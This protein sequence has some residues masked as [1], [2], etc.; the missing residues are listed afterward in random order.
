MWDRAGAHKTPRFGKLN[1]I[2]HRVHKIKS[3]DIL[4]LS[5]WRWAGRMETD[6][7]M[8][9]YVV[10][11]FRILNSLS[12]QG[13]AY[14][15]INTV[16]FISNLIFSR[17]WNRSVACERERESIVPSLS[18]VGA[19]RNWV[20]SQMAPWRHTTWNKSIAF[21]KPKSKFKSRFAHRQMRK[22]KNTIF[23]NDSSIL[24]SRS[25]CSDALSL[26]TFA[27]APPSGECCSFVWAAENRRKEEPERAR[28]C[29]RGRKWFFNE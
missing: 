16:D 10:M 26:A 20:H 18:C 17:D 24:Q 7:W 14:K 8:D 13:N 22:S 11:A 19:V 15:R 2:I 4:Y 21:E 29:K 9:Y 6:G 5:A 25:V 1:Q 28:E 12:L 23:L 3:I 27:P